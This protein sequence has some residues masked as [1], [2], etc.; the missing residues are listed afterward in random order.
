MS[1]VQYN[2]CTNTLHTDRA[3][4]RKLQVPVY[5][6]QTKMFKFIFILFNIIFIKLKMTALREESYLMK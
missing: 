5:M 2:T 6:S 3:K 1:K 4:L